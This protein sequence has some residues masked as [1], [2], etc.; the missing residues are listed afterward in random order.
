MDVFFVMSSG[1]FRTRTALEETGS[2][3]GIEI[4]SNSLEV[5]ADGRTTVGIVAGVQV[6][7][8][9]SVGCIGNLDLLGHACIL[10]YSFA[11]VAFVQLWHGHGCR[12]PVVRVAISLDYL[13]CRVISCVISYISNGTDPQSNHYCLMC[14]ALETKGRFLGCSSHIFSQ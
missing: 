4:V 11:L 5:G 2:R 13:V 14:S 6:G 12:S 9:M 7:W 10:G 1:D 8:M 3:M